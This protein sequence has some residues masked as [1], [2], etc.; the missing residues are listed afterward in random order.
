MREALHCLG[1]VSPNCRQ[2]VKAAIEHV[3]RA[4]GWFEEAGAA[5]DNDDRI[6]DDSGGLA[7]IR[8][9]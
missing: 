3:E 1:M 5:N 4:N 2:H 6:G 7:D 8:A 9:R